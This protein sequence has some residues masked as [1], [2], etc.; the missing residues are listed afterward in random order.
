MHRTKY[1]R[2]SAGWPWL[3]HSCATSS[4]GTSAI[5]IS[6]RN[7]AFVLDMAFG[8]EP[9][10]HDYGTRGGGLLNLRPKSFINASRD[11]MAAMEDLRD[12]QERYHT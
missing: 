12:M 3:P 9:V 7:R 1:P 11:M 2:C 8:P 10:A 5:P 4:A 6:I